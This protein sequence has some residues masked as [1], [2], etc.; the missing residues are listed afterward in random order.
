MDRERKD[1]ELKEKFETLRVVCSDPRA[2]PC[3]FLLSFG[4]KY[5]IT[6]R[7]LTRANL[8]ARGLK[9]KR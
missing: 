4:P 1:K 2:Q 8:L 6:L 5:S 7:L 9:T 3:L